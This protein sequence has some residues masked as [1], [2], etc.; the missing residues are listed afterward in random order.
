V[1]GVP[2]GTTTLQLA[3]SAVDP[4][5]LGSLRGREAIRHVIVDDTSNLPDCRFLAALPEVESLVLQG[6]RLVSAAG[7]EGAPALRRVHVDVGRNNRVT[8]DALRGSAIVRLHV[9]GVRGIDLTEIAR[10]P[11]L[12]ELTLKGGEVTDLAALAG[13]SVASVRCI[14][15]PLTDA[16]GG[17]ALGSLR[18]LW[19]SSCRDLVSLH[20]HAHVT[21]LTVEACGK[22]DAATVVAAPAL[23]TLTL[24]ACKR[25]FDLSALA[26]LRHLAQVNLTQCAVATGDAVPLGWAS[27]RRAW[28]SPIGKGPLQAWSEANPGGVWTNGKQAFRAGQDVPVAEYHA[29]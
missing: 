11:R 7:T 3:G 19:F 16:K 18:E 25:P 1:Q 5:W 2:E 6:K 9:T 27:L 24:L 21:A 13:S 4:S 29:A 10:I 12:E 28:V 8:L 14:G 23:E 20:P 15:G 22:F 26:G 17:D